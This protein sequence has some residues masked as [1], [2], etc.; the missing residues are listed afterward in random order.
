MMELLAPYGNSINTNL[1]R[2]ISLT[3]LDYNGNKISIE[4]NN[5][6]LIEIIIPRD[7][8]LIIP[9]M[10]LQNVISL[11]QS[12]HMK[13]IQLN[14]SLTVSIHFDIHPLKKNLSYLFI[15]QFDQLLQC[16]QLDGS[17]LFCPSS[18]LII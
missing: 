15:Y 1:S 9:P 6:H 11:N 5:S 13:L 3:I 16:D 12:Y 10:I 7:P 4:T 18:K 2:S 8:N 17:I 14:Q